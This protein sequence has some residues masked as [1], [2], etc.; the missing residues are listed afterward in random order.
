MEKANKGISVGGN[1]YSSKYG[2]AGFTGLSS[3]GSHGR[4]LGMSFGKSLTTSD[5]AGF[6][7]F[8]TYSTPV[9]SVDCSMG[10]TPILAAGWTFGTLKL[11]G[12]NKINS[13]WGLFGLT[14]LGSTWPYF[15]WSNSSTLEKRQ[16]EDY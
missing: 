1:V 10:F 3:Q 11:L 16:K 7:G 14:T 2:G 4:Y 6:G 12:G 9:L 8:A 5:S 13:P 15:K